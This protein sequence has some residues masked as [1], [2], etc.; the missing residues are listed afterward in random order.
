[1]SGC[2]VITGAAGGIGAGLARAAAGRGY[3]AVLADCD[4][5]GITSL[6]QE[7]GPAAIPVLADVTDRQSMERLARCAFAAGPLELL[8]ANAG[9]LQTGLTWQ[10]S[11]ADWRRSLDVNIMGVVNTIAAFVPQ[12]IEAGLPA[13]IVITA[14]VGGFL[15]SPLLGPYSATKFALVAIAEGLAGELAASGAPISVSLLAPGPVKSGIFQAD[16][17]P[18]TAGFVDLMRGMLETDGIDGD[19]CARR[20]FAAID[21]RAYWIVPQPEMLDKPLAQRHAMI[22]ERRPPT[23]YEPTE[24]SHVKENQ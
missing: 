8:F 18:A 16:P 1:M 7:I 13:R 2:A 24:N 5:P 11:E 23:F 4:E 15:P 9:I 22:A 19:E 14:S 20:V 3:T 12:M 17:P 10:I 21:E 6:A